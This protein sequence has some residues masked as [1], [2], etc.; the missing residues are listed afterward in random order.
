VTSVSVST[1]ESLVLASDFDGTTRLLRFD[2]GTQVGPPLANGSMPAFERANEPL[3]RGTFSAF[4]PGTH[5]A[6]IFDSTDGAVRLVDVDSRTERSPRVT[7]LP[8]ASFW[9]VSPD[10]RVAAVGSATGATQLYDLQT[11][12]QIGDPF[13]SALDLG[14]HTSDGRSMVT[15]DA[16]PVVWDVDPASWREKACTVAGR[17]MTR[18]E[19]EQHM[20]PDERYRVTCPEHLVEN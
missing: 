1:D 18:A 13:P 20:P 17:N 8:G 15:L 10:G 3:V 14:F 2:D 12:T 7:V 16:P 5:V 11:G 6:L 4:L 19:W 9:D